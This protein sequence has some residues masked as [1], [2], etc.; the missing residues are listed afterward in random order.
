[1][2]ME[3]TL[4]KLV[5]YVFGVSAGLVGGLLSLLGLL[6]AFGNLAGGLSVLAAG[7]LLLG[8][9]AI[10]LPIARS[11]VARKFDIELSAGA[12]AAI[13]GGATVFAVSI[14]LL[15]GIAAILSGGGGAA[16]NAA[17]TTQ[18]AVSQVD[19]QPSKTAGDA[20]IYEDNPA[21]LAISYNDHAQKSVDPSSDDYSAYYADDGSK[22]LVVQMEITNA[23]ETEV[24]VSPRSF[25]IVIN[26]VEY[27]YQPL[28]GSGAQLSSVTLQP[29]ATVQGWVVFQV[30]QDVTWA[31]IELNEGSYMS[32]PGADFSH[33]SNMT[34]RAEPA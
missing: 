19:V 30:P 26:G 11:V 5:A 18:A 4:P 23:G 29:G 31:S 32:A 25:L 9:A 22:M 24:E 17:T 3:I 14:L 13:S 15:V 27:S 10:A 33:D 7:V 28:Q 20:T 6:I 34:V 21:R 8:A 12:T 1:M 16:S 2:I